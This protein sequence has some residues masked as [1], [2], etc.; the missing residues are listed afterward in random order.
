MKVFA[1]ASHRDYDSMRAVRVYAAAWAEIAYVP[2]ALAGVK[3]HAVFAGRKKEVDAFDHL[4]YPHVLISLAYDPDHSF[5]AERLGYRPPDWLGDSG[6]F[7][8]WTV[9][10]KVELD[11]LIEWCRWHVAAEPGFRCISLDVIPGDSGGD[12]APTRKERERAIAE[13]LANGD[14][15]REAGLK[16]TEVFHVFE[17]LDHLELLL[18]R[19]QPGEVLGLGGM[20]GRS[21]GL[22]QQFCDAAFAFVRDWSGGWEE[23][24]PLHGLGIEVMRPIAA[25]YP[26]ASVDASSWVAPGKFGYGVARNGKLL[27]MGDQTNRHPSARHLA[28]VRVLEGW[29]AREAALTRLWHDRGVRFRA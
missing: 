27:R 18:E 25:R 6:A 2:E 4:G 11:R 28:L 21:R 15:M 19:R 1:T 16:I 24:V 14:A 26:W 8:A 9:G 22:K 12:R 3:A 7:T 10:E 17:P 23:L 13:S 20:V 5:F 29:L